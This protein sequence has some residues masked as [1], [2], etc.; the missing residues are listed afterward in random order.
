MK[1]STKGKR[2][3]GLKV[4]IAIAVLL[5]S[6]NANKKLALADTTSYGTIYD[7]DYTGN[8][9]YRFVTVTGDQ[10][11]TSYEAVAGQPTNGTY[12]K[13]GDGLYYSTSGG[14][15]VTVSI[16]VN[17][18]CAAVGIAVPLGKIGTST[19]YGKFLTASQSGYYKIYAKK[20]VTPKV[21]YIQ[22]RSRTY[23]YPAGYTWSGWST[24]VY[25]KTY[26]VNKEY[27]ALVKQ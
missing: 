5:F 24:R 13:K 17:F 4:I 21:V 20:Y 16:G 2:I 6:V 12:L 27:S 9:Q 26:T 14:N 10:R 1:Q 25:S 7:Y 8:R 3:L 23:N 15:C 11:W 19:N 18:G 22:E